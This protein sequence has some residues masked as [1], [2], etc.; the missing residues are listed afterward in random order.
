[1]FHRT[2]TVSVKCNS[3]K[4]VVQM[5]KAHDF[6]SIISKD[7]PTIDALKVFSYEKDVELSEQVISAFN[8][9]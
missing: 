9:I 3:V 6:M 1:M 4:G 7:Q 2:N 5:I 8:V